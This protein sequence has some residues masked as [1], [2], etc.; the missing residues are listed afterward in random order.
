MGLSSLTGYAIN[1][2][3]SVLRKLA[4]EKKAEKTGIMVE[5]SDLS[6]VP[7]GLD[8]S[9]TRPTATLGRVNVLSLLL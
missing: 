7:L 1:F 3:E 2:Q 8:L 4:W 9:L 6:L 5:G